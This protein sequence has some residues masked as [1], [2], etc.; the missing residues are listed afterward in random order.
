MIRDREYELTTARQRRMDSA[1]IGQL[2]RENIALK[3]RVA[4][5]EE[6]LAE[7]EGDK[8]QQALEGW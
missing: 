1:T 3:Q 2:A 4:E 8:N 5:L 7:H 6:R